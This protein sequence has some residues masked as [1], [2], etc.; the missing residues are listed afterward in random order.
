M[1][2]AKAKTAKT[3]D[4]YNDFMR[5][6]EYSWTFQRMSNAEKLDCYEALNWA[7]LNGAIKGTYC[8]RYIVLQAIYNAYLIGI[9]YDGPNWREPNNAE[10]RFNGGVKQ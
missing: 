1:Q 3:A 5:T 8:A 7:M 10:I 6:L 4:A 2:E 9:G